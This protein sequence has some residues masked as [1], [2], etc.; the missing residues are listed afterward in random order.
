MNVMKQS[1][2]AL[3]AAASFGVAATAN[4]DLT[5][6]WTL[7][8]GSDTGTGYFQTTSYLTSPNSSYPGVAGYLITKVIDSSINGD[9]VSGIVDTAT[10]ANAGSGWDQLL[11]PN[12]I[13]NEASLVDGNGILLT[14]EHAAYAYAGI[15]STG[16]PDNPEEVL[17]GEFNDINSY[18]LNMGNFSANFTLTLVPTPEPSQV[19]SMLGLAGLGG[20]SL[21]RR[22][23]H[24]K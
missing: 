4:A 19:V 21:L 16:N 5:W 6:K 11:V 22:L 1:T 17:S 7:S 14:L 12:G 9:T 20:L 18:G 13:V 8:G 2:L 10:A 24:Q 15:Y 23:R 3:L